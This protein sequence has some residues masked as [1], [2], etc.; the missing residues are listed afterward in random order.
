VSARRAAQRAL[1]DIRPG[2]AARHVGAGACLV[3]EDQPALK[4]RL[5]GSPRLSRFGHVR[6]LLLAGVHGFF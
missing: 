3:E 6:P 4:L 2:M 5:R 1:A